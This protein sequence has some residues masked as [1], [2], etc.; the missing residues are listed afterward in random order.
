MKFIRRDE[1]D[2][3]MVSVRLREVEGRPSGEIFLPMRQ[4]P[5]AMTTASAPQGGALS[6]AEALGLATA[7]AFE[8]RTD[9]AVIDEDQLWRPEWGTLHETA[10]DPLPG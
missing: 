10:G 9:I 2:H 5:E 6:A 4:R 3:A 1:P 7:H 8:L